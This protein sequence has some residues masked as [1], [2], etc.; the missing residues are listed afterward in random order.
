MHCWEKVWKNTEDLK[1]NLKDTDSWWL[2]LLLMMPSNGKLMFNYNYYKF[3]GQRNYPN[4][5]GTSTIDN[6]CISII[7]EL[8][9]WIVEQVQ[10][11]FQ[12]EQN[13]GMDWEWKWQFTKVLPNMRETSILINST[14]YVFFRIFFLKRN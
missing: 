10:L 7:I 13:Y 4:I 11:Y 6:I 5:Q 8:I 9:F 1:L 12:M 3:L 14:T 2:S